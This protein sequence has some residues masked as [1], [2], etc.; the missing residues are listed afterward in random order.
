MK[1][2]FGYTVFMTMSKVKINL[3]FLRLN[4]CREEFLIITI[5]IFKMNCVIV[6]KQNVKLDDKVVKGRDWRW[7]SQGVFQDMELLNLLK[8]IIG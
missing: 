2:P 1:F 3:F 4:G 5:N 7:D 8:T 6:T